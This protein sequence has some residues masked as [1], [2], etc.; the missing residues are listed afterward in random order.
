M[1]A[2]GK[3]PNVQAFVE[4]A[5]IRQDIL[6]HLEAE[7]PLYVAGKKPKRWLYA[8]LGAGLTLLLSS[9]LLYFRAVP[10]APRPIVFLLG[11][12]GL[13]GVVAGIMSDHSS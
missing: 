12:G 13:T 6:Y 2:A 5:I 7:A 11:I 9:P 8:L 3:A 10:F 4:T 1:V